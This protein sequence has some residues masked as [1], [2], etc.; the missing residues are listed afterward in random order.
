MVDVHYI[1]SS[2]GGREHLSMIPTG[3][4]QKVKGA[5]S[6]GIIVTS[7]SIIDFERTMCAFDDVALAIRAENN[8]AGDAGV[9]ANELGDGMGPC[10]GVSKEEEGNDSLDMNKENEKTDGGK[11]D[12]TKDYPGRPTSTFPSCLL[13]A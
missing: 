11:P 5:E 7:S 2:V 12:K 3:V 6:M 9:A 4:I 8:V 13:I 1:C 10:G